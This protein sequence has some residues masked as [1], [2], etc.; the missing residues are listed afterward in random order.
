MGTRVPARSRSRWRC[1][2]RHT[3]GAT[4]GSV[5]MPPGSR[6]GAPRSVEV[7]RAHRAK[8]CLVGLRTPV[9]RS[10]ATKGGWVVQSVRRA[11]VIVALL[12]GVRAARGT[13][14]DDLCAPLADP[15]VV[16][17]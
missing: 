9:L 15:C 1:A 17:G 14:A 7:R 6:P 5:P 8:V 10:A 16:G 13:V 2:R 4:P 3:P 11:T 12:L